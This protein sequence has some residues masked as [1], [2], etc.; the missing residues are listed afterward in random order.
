MNSSKLSASK[1]GLYSFTAFIIF[2]LFGRILF[3]PGDEPDFEVKSMQMLDFYKE[4]NLD[5]F[6]IHLTDT[7]CSYQHD[8]KSI[9]FTITDCYDN[10]HNVLKRTLWLLIISFPLFF[11]LLKKEKTLSNLD[12][13]ARKKTLIAIMPFPSIIYFSGL[14]SNEQTTLLLSLFIFLFWDKFLIKLL[15]LTLITVIDVGN[16]IVVLFFITNVY[17]LNTINHKASK[18]ITRII[19]TLLVSILLTYLFPLLIDFSTLFTNKVYSILSVIDSGGYNS[20]LSPIIR[21]IITFT[22]IIFMTS[23]YIKAPISYAFLLIALLYSISLKAVLIKKESS[24]I[25]LSPSVSIYSSILTILLITLSIPTYSYGKY[26]AF[27]IP[28]IFYYFQQKHDQS[29]ILLFSIFLSITVFLHLAFYRF[30]G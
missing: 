28:F 30:Y 12:Y 15:L 29:R 10:T 1:Y 6:L 11:F 19:L 2:S 16:G 7:S 27:L 8:P 24:L 23:A 20:E 5:F 25:S 13:I 26:Y 17:F 9:F 18:K 21:P 4:Y 3:V 22:S 14:Y